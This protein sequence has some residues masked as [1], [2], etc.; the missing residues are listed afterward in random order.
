M[1]G[2]VGFVGATRPDARALLGRMADALAH[3]GP[4]AAGFHVAAF[5]NG[6]HQVG[7]GHRR[8]AIID[9]ASGDQPIARPSATT[10]GTTG[11]V[12][13]AVAGSAIVGGLPSRVRKLPR[14]A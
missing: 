2:I 11:A 4:D 6:Q 13:M 5:A 8:L 1:C 9:L 3:R 14:R 12:S 7:L 10:G